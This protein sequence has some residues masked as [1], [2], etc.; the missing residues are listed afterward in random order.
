MGLGPVGG[1]TSAGGG[2]S[3]LESM[4]LVFVLLAWLMIGRAG[5]KTQGQKA[6]VAET[7]SDVSKNEG[8]Q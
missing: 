4:W 2:R 6:P 1:Q 5:R 3:D 7:R 8:V